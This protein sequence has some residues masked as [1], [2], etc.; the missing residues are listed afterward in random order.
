MS[1]KLLIVENEEPQIKLLRDAIEIYNKNG[2][3]QIILDEATNLNQGLEKL[4]TNDYDGA[5]VDLRL[6]QNDTVGLG[7]QILKEI[8]SRLRFPVR[9]ISGHLG[10]LDAELQEENYLYSCKNRGDEDYDSILSEFVDIYSTGITGILNNKGLIEKNI[11]TIF[12]KHLSIILPVFVKHKAENKGW[13]GEKVLLRYISS[14]ILEYLEISI[15]NNL[16]PVHPIEFYI[17]P[18]IKD[19]IFTGDIIRFK[20]TNDFGVILTPA[21]DLATDANRL[22]PKAKFVTVACIYKYADVVHG[23]KPEHVTELVKNN[24]DLKYHFLPKTI[25]FEGGFVNFQHIISIPIKQIA[26]KGQFEVECV[27]TNPFRKDIISRFANYFAR[28]GQPSFE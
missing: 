13:D 12:W 22:K 9:V 1:I 11:N 24:L 28:Q 23:R 6:E 5:I 18:P 19:K 21:C 8:K 3:I 10:D 20:N 2:G 15:E 25:L 7:N 4:R 26:D 27:I 16:E 17:K 14:H